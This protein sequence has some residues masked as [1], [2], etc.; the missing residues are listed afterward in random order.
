VEGSVLQAFARLARRASTFRSSTVLLFRHEQPLEPDPS[1]DIRPVNESMLGDAREMES[2]SMIE[3]FRQF[4]RQGDWGYF[5]Y[6]DG[7]MA[8]RSWVQLG[9]RRVPLWHRFVPHE[10]RSGEALI[11]YCET[12]PTARGAGLYT[13]ALK[14]IVRDLRAHSIETIWIS[15]TADNAAS[16]RA[17]EKAGFREHSRFQVRVLFGVGLQRR[18]PAIPS[19]GAA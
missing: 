5:G 15:T 14:R 6:R 8:H 13:A 4:L 17:I 11:H 18:I 10:V 9:P 3:T 7:R 19:P 2:P 16:R 12:T 1:V